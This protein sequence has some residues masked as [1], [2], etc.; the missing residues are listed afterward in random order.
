MHIHRRC[1][2]SEVH[3]LAHYMKQRPFLKADG[4]Q[5]CEGIS[6]LCSQEFA[7]GPCPEAAEPSPH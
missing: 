5:Y 4:L 7:N 3:Y 1:N 6:V 2:K